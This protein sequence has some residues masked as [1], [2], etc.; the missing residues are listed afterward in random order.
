MRFYARFEPK[1]T[2]FS[3]CLKNKEVGICHFRSKMGRNLE[4]FAQNLIF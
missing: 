1:L 4:E 3:P 2:I